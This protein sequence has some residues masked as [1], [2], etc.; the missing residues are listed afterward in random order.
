MAVVQ[1]LACHLL[2][3]CVWSN[4]LMGIV[5][6]RVVVKMKWNYTC[7]VLSMVPDVQWVLPSYLLS[8]DYCRGLCNILLSLNM[9]LKLPYLSGFVSH[10]LASNS[11]HN[12]LVVVSLRFHNLFSLHILKLCLLRTPFSFF[13]FFSHYYPSELSAGNIISM[14]LSSI[15]VLCLHGLLGILSAS[16]ITL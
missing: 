16:H 14:K 5:I 13:C 10:Y 2:I 11:S 8:L 3:S 9:E 6:L 4:F 1:G 15:L 12:E 7:E